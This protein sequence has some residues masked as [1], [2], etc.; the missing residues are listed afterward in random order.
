MRTERDLRA[1]LAGEITVVVVGVVGRI[2]ILAAAVVVATV[3]L[4]ESENVVLHHIGFAPAPEVEN[5][6]A[7]EGAD[8]VEDLIVTSGENDAADFVADAYIP[9]DDLALRLAV[10]VDTEAS[11][12]ENDI[13]VDRQVFSGAINAV[14]PA[15][16]A[17]LEDDVAFH[18]NL[19]AAVA[20]LLQAAVDVAVDDVVG[21]PATDTRLT[22]PRDAIRSVGF[23]LRRFLPSER[24]FDHET[25]D[26]NVASALE[27]DDGPARILG[28]ILFG[29]GDFDLAQGIRGT[30][31]DD[32][33]A[34]LAGL[35][36]DQ[37]L[38]VGT[39]PDINKIPGL[40][41]RDGGLDGP[42]WLLGRTV[43]RVLTM[44]IDPPDRALGSVFP[45]TDHWSDKGPFILVRLDGDG[46][47]VLVEG[48][49]RCNRLSFG[50]GAKKTRQGKTCRNCHKRSHWYFLVTV[51]IEI[52]CRVKF[53]STHLNN[54]PEPRWVQQRSSGQIAHLI[55]N[56][57]VVGLRF[58]NRSFA[59]R[60]LVAATSG[61]ASNPHKASSAPISL[62]LPT[63]IVR[64]F[65]DLPPWNGNCRYG[66]VI[67]WWSARCW[68]PCSLF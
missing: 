4:I 7:V 65:F 14:V 45:R 41:L 61:C 63:T 20:H 46:L 44:M 2:A 38:D 12:V 10:A 29:R 51:S 57:G 22:G 28:D 32:W 59:N 55:G 6:D 42:E 62:R 67:G 37:M 56:P 39:C 68:P 9:G 50:I 26:P 16:G 13:S 1:R 19:R 34:F 58:A 43:V 54:A 25:V 35:R 31:E 11:V 18:E 52:V 24:A 40:G 3:G 33:F 49:K 47:L 8:V 53:Y 60:Y 66:R 36:N 30:T 17:V 48:N 27:R 21:G 23:H 5:A 15:L 64:R